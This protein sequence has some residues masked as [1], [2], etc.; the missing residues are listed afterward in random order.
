MCVCVSF[1]YSASPNLHFLID[2]VLLS[3]SVAHQKVPYLIC[4]WCVSERILISMFCCARAFRRQQHEF[5]TFENH[6]CVCI[7]VSLL[8]IRSRFVCC[9]IIHISICISRRF[10]SAAYTAVSTYTEQRL[11]VDGS[12]GNEYRRFCLLLS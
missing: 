7:C 8:F 10:H 4:Y 6:N 5:Q 9:A 1:Y 2:N 3:L 11:Y 12:N